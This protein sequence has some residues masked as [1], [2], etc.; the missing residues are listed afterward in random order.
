[1]VR[2]ARTSGESP[3][4][5]KALIAR[6]TE[7]MEDFL[8]PDCGLPIDKR[9]QGVGWVTSD[10]GEY[11]VMWE[12]ITYECG[13]VTHDGEVLVPCGRRALEPVV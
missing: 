5:L 4:R 12:D 9:E 7:L 11:D 3:S 2:V 1:V 8:C 6:A 13:R 10:L